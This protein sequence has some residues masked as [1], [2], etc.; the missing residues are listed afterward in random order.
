MNILKKR[1]KYHR[2]WLFLPLIFLV[3]IPFQKNPYFA[4]VTMRVFISCVMAMGLDIC[5]GVSGQV[6]L[7]QAGFMGIG[8][9]VA[10]KLMQTHSSLGALTLAVVLAVLV[11][12]VL[13]F[14]IGYFI[15]R[16]K[17]DYLGIATMALGEI[18]CLYFQTSEFFGKARGLFN[19]TK[20]NNIGLSFFLFVV[21][22]IIG[23]WFL[24]S[25]TGFLSYA[26]GQ[27]ETAAK[28]VGIDTVNLK[29]FSFVLSAVVC[30]LA[31]V[32]YS[33]TLGFISPGDFDFGRST[34]CLAAVILGGPRTIV[35]PAIAAAIIELSTIFLQPIAEYRMVIYGVLLVYFA[36]VRY[37]EKKKKKAA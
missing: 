11:T 32:L 2:L 20:Y 7:G 37:K 35:G 16:L 21:V 26:T 33:G 25:K 3:L 31:G 29:I 4:L 9:Y 19:I 34:D 15:L 17:G 28:S 23:L 1:K 36:G 12:G 5:T 30:A 13:A 22:L 27:D 14:F 6:S 8:G 18:I 24:N 10:A